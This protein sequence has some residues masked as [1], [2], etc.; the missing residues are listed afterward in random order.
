MK[1]LRAA[2]VQFTLLLFAAAAF[3]QPMRIDF[4]QAANNDRPYPAGDVHWI[5]SILQSNNATYYEGM[6]VPQR[7]VLTNIPSTSNN[8]HSLTF[9]HKATKSGSHAYDF[10]TSYAQAV[11][12]A[13]AIVG[14]T[15]LQNLNRCGDGIG[16]PKGMQTTCNDLISTGAHA[17]VPIPGNLGS[18]LGHDV[19][20]RIAAYDTRFITY[21]RVLDMYGNQ[22]I[23]NAS[24]TFDGYTTGNDVSAQYTLTWTSASTSLLIEFAA[25]LALGTDVPGAGTGIAY[26]AGYGAGSISGG[27]YHIRLDQLDGSALGAQDNQIMSAAVRMSISCALAGPSPVCMNDQVQYSF[28]SSASGLTYSWSLQDN[29]SSASIV[30]ST[31]GSSITVDAG[32][33]NGSYTVSVIVRDAVQTTVCTLPVTVNGFTV[34]AAPLPLLCAG[35]KTPVTVSAT[36]GLAPYTG[37]GTFLKH[38]GTYTF[39]VTDANGCTGSTTVTVTEPEALIASSSAAQLPCSGGTTAVTVSAKGGKPPY[40]G[41]GTFQRGVGNHTFT[42]TDANNCVSITQLSIA[43]PSA[44]A[45]AVNAPDIDCYGG[46]STVTVSAGGGTPPYSGTGTFQRSAG[47]HSFTVTD[48]NGCTETAIVT[49]S[50][51]S[52]ALAV[53]ASATPISCHGGMSTVTV[54]ATGGTPPYTGTGSSQRAAGTYT[55]TVTDANGCSAGTVPV[56]ITQPATALSV[57]ATTTPIL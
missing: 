12:A 10:L 56:V 25:H 55:F 54:N 13:N 4:R 3:A 41:T 50:Q 40:N 1:A 49:I 11:A 24:L 9:S 28:N 44:L 19:S 30:G 8:Q 27:S 6:S 42:V 2:L 34:T 18:V 31:T 52:A 47:T 26:G 53:T 20:T 51:P 39:T 45:I 36:G 17:A 32:N 21:P 14:V 43:A 38:A 22:A 29:S 37:T 7:I 23:T 46:M 48:A 57:S 15:A 16:P 33:S 35:N 5:Q